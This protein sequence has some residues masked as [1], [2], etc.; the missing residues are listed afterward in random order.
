MKRIL[1]YFVIPDHIDVGDVIAT[2]YQDRENQVSDDDLE[3][4]DAT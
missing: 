1:R 2:R 4:G 3:V